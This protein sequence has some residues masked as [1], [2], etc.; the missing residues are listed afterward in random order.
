[1]QGKNCSTPLDANGELVGLPASKRQN[2]PSKTVKKKKNCRKEPTKEE[3]KHSPTQKYTICQKKVSDPADN[4]MNP[5]EPEVQVVSDDDVVVVETAAAEEPEE[6]DEAKLG[7]YLYQI[8]QLAADLFK[9]TCRGN[10]PHQYMYSLKRL[11]KLSIKAVIVVMYLN[12]LPVDV[13]AVM[14]V[15]S[16]DFL[17]KVMLT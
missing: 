8:E 7:V 6:D 17:T 15:L 16:L 9:C 3:K 10:G 5:Q 11:L 2:Q 14:G 13:K 1:M 12:V 4:A